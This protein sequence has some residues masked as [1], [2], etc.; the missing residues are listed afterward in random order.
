MCLQLHLNAH[1]QSSSVQEN[2]PQEMPRGEQGLKPTQESNDS[3]TENNN[4]SIY[5][6]YQKIID[7]EISN[8]V[9][10]AK[11]I[12]GE[13]LV[14]SQLLVEVFERACPV[15]E[16]VAACR[17]PEEPS[18]LQNCLKPVGE[19]IMEV[20]NLQSTASPRTPF[21]NHFKVVGEAAQSLS[22]L[23]YTGPSCGMELPPS[24]VEGCSN[25]VDF[26]ANKV[27]AEWRSKDPRHAKWVVSIQKL[28]RALSQYCSNYHAI[29]LAWNTSPN[30]PTVENFTVL[31]ENSCVGAAKN[32]NRG[33]PPPAPPP[34]PPGTLLRPR[35]GNGKIDSSPTAAPVAKSS[36]MAAVLADLNRGEAVTAGLRKVTDDMK[37][38]NRKERNSSEAKVVSNEGKKSTSSHFSAQAQTKRPPRMECEQ[39]RKWVIENFL[40]DH[41]ILVS[42]TEPR[43][44]VQIFNCSNCTIKICGKVNAIIL[45][46]C[47]KTGL[48]FDS[49]VSTCEVVN[50]K[51][52]E[53]QCCEAVPCFAIDNTD[54]CRIHL[55]ENI[56]DGI[57]INTAKSSELNICVLP[58]SHE[59]D[60]AEYPIPE[61][62]VTRRLNGAWV[63]E[64]LSHSAG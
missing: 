54:G 42:D 14:A 61:Q 51:S 3:A 22:F 53:V 40:D 10:S 7:D 43:Q 64:P 20:A 57:D 11:D 38:K 29:S 2:A 18:S 16:K 5:T 24:H 35:D 33:P 37:S 47:V 32:A 34:P 44:A 60:V 36:S 17:K 4:V 49:V 27:L 31:P 6:A 1:N 52:V 12:G 39:G 26:Y 55:N 63:T 56:A 25:A 9:E 19:K 13:V 50:C 30:A 15:L 28:M 45:D 41:S 21:M 46:G 58:V 8:V 48:L 23:A 59:D 62:F